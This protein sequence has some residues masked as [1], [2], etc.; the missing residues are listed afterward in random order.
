[1]GKP[2]IIKTT[3]SGFFNLRF[4][5]DSERKNRLIKSI[6]PTPEEGLKFFI[7]KRLKFEK[8]M[9]EFCS[10]FMYPPGEKLF[11]CGAGVGSGC[12]DAYGFFSPC[13]ML[14]YPDTTY[15][16]KNGSFKDTMI[17]FFPEV[18]KMKAKNPNYLARS[19]R[20]FLKGLCEKCPVKSWTEHGTLDTPVEYLCQ[21]AHLQARY[22]GL[23]DK[24]EM[25][26]E[27]KDWRERIHKF[28]GKD[29]I[30]QKRRQPEMISCEG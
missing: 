8:D 1:M 29:T 2:P 26:W 4:R 19:A 17:N 14:K 7:R 24:G 28:T 9:K 30:T 13:L 20:C 21:I 22:L 3:L 6:K 27:M 11:S 23:I 16:L 15:D 10:K 5:R 25:A 12:V 18:R